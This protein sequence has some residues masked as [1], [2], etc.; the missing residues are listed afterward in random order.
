MTKFQDSIEATEHIDAMQ[1]MLQDERL[2][3]WVNATDRNFGTR[4]AHMLAVA[5]AAVV[6]LYEELNKAE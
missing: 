4:A 2:T 6:D 3:E 1:A 5:R